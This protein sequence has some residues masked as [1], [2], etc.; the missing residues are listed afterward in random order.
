MGRCGLPSITGGKRKERPRALPRSCSAIPPGSMP[1]RPS[2]SHP[3]TPCAT[4]RSCPEHPECQL[5]PHPVGS[6]GPRWLGPEPRG[7][8]SAALE[9]TRTPSGTPESLG[10]AGRSEKS[11]RSCLAAVG[12]SSEPAEA[13]F[14]PPL[15]PSLQ[16]PVP[17]PSLGC[18]GRVGAGTP[19]TRGCPRKV[20]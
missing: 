8:D 5:P 11:S 16:G 6:A 14:Q 18:K 1:A 13:P 2:Y 17:P 15:P 10:T 20:C 12:D 19:G 7:R 4:V 3:G 9:A